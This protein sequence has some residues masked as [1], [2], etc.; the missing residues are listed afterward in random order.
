MKKIIVFGATGGT[1]RQV[2]EQALQS[3]YQV[4]VVARNPDAFPLRYA[5]LTVIRGDVLQPDTFQQA[6]SGQDVVISCLGSQKREPTSLYSEGI[7][8]I[9]DAM[10][11]AGVDRLLCLSAIAV[12]VPPH[13]SWL[14]KLVTKHILQRLFKHLYADMLRMEEFLRGSSLNWTVVRPPQLTDGKPT[15]CYRTTLN[16]PIRNP[17]KISRADLAHYL[18]SHLTD[19]ATFRV[20]VEV[21][22]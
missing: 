7:Q 13:G 3:E 20:Q 15:G 11:Q 6:M 14:I 22:Y 4:T 18:L 17:T 2:V 12:E 1:G 16:E 8:N 19:E 9:A 5:Q 21:S 10:Q